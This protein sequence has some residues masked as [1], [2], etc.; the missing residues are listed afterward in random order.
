VTAGTYRDEDPDNALVLARAPTAALSAAGLLLGYGVAVASG[1][2][3][4]GGLV[5]SA[6]GLACIAI[7]LHRDGR[8]TALVLTIAGL[9]AFVLSHV[10]ALLIGAWPAVALAAAAT[11]TACWRLSDTR[12]EHVVIVIG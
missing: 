7:W 3:G 2:R 12:R 8:R 9:T 4:L 11:A 5:L 1:S 6:F 10:V